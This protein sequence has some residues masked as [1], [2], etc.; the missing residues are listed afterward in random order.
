MFVSSWSAANTLGTGH[1]E[2]IEQ[3]NGST[4]EVRLLGDRYNSWYENRDGYVLDRDVA[5]AFVY[6]LPA[7]TGKKIYLGDET[8]E[9]AVKSKTLTRNFKPTIEYSSNNNNQSVSDARSHSIEINRNQPIVVALVN[10]NGTTL[11]YSSD[12]FRE[13][14]FGETNSVKAFFKTTSYGSYNI[15]PAKET[16]G[17]QNDGV[18]TVTL[19]RPHPDGQGDNAGRDTVTDVFKALD[20]YVD[21]KQYDTNNDGKISPTELSVVL[22]YAGYEESYSGAGTPS[23]WGH[24]SGVSGTIVDGVEISDYTAFG[25]RHGPQDDYHQASIGI[26]C[27]ELGHLMLDL[28]DLYAY[29]NGF[30]YHKWGLMAGG[31]WGTEPG[32][33]NTMG[34]KPSQLSGW[35]KERLG[36]VDFKNVE[37][38]NRSL[39]LRPADSYGD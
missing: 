7:R 17:T 16:Q 15:Q 2:K 23:V 27:H 3:P 24:R 22:I 38:K 31:S 9:G 35:S 29:E 11:K 18:V 6:R 33:G 32:F 14:I 4:H 36:L 30:G 25:E 39:T 13:L 37:G 5:G 26:M 19:S 12:S 8:P 34:A 1:W 28:P 10:F 21:Y 20:Y